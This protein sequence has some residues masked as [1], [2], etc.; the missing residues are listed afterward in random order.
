LALDGGAVG[1]RGA[2]AKLFDIESV[3][4]VRLKK[5]I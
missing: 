1:L 2:A 5:D 4:V 3:H